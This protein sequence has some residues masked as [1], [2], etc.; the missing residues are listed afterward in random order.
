MRCNMH[1]IT[2]ATLYNYHEAKENF[3]AIY[4][5][6]HSQVLRNKS[7]IIKHIEVSA[8]NRTAWDDYFWK[9]LI[10]F[11]RDFGPIYYAIL[12]NNSYFIG[13]LCCCDSFVL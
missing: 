10:R 11:T 9:T 13:I 1:R 8:S 4:S 6:S 12:R 7:K 2:Q 5:L 3:N